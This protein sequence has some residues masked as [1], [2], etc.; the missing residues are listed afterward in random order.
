MELN[1]KSLYKGPVERQEVEEAIQDADWQELRKAMKGVS[2]QQKYE[3][4]RSYC[5]QAKLDLTFKY[6]AGD[7]VEEPAGT[8]SHDL[9]MVE[10]RV[11]N[12][13]TALSRGRLIKPEDYR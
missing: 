5:G 3:M 9:R 2:L 1:W 7:Y 11:T 13:I 4:L 12:Y 10:V 8:Y 6:L